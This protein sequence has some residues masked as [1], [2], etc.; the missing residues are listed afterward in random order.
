M[1]AKVYFY[2]PIT[3]F[4]S[5]GN[6]YVKFPIPLFNT[7]SMFIICSQMQTTNWQM[8]CQKWLQSIW[9]ASYQKHQRLVW[10]LYISI[11]NPY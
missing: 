11:A 3:F 8:I 9:R 1:P 10:V 5:T 7:E 6:S 2:I 4:N